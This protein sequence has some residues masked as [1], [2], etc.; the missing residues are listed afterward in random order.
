LTRSDPDVLIIGAGVIGLCS[1]YYLAER[2]CSVTIVER[3]TICN[4]RSSD[5]RDLSKDDG[6]SCGNAGL[7]VPSHSIP[8][9]SPGVVSQ[10]LRWMLDPESPFYIKPRLDFDLA[11]WLWQFARAANKRAVRAAIPIL[12]DLQRASR[13]LFAGLASAP[14]LEFGYSQQGLVSLFRTVDGLAHAAEEARLLRQHGLASEVLDADAVAE[15]VPAVGHDIIGGVRHMEDAHVDPAAFVRGM[16][17]KVEALGVELRASTEVEGFETADRPSTGS[18]RPVVQRV[19]TNKGDLAPAQI[20]LAAGAWAPQVAAELGVHLPIQAAKG[21]SITLP[22][23][24]NGPNFPL[25]LGET[26]VVATPMGAGAGR[27]RFAGTLELAG[28]DRSINRRRV[29][30][31]RRAA[32]IYL[33]GL[34]DWE[35]DSSADDG[36]TV[37]AGLRPCSPDGLPLVGRVSRYDNLAV[38]GGHATLGLSLGPITGELV[39]DVVMGE[40]PRFDVALLDPDRFG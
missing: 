29:E 34:R 4:F 19:R 13:Q 8:L 12:R 20:V 14:D 37:W 18:G 27:L 32:R 24:E 16:A 39:A 25:Y 17:R 26:R 11:M 38:A 31:I 3:G 35:A 1:A 7:V 9:A 22:R 15:A 33:P 40:T 23:P 10:A 28:L 36:E 2:G 21:Y 30:A 6:C 5:T